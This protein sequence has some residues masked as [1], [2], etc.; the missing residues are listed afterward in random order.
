MSKRDR[1][2]N[3]GDGSDEGAQLLTSLSPKKASK[4]KK[5][6]SRSACSSV[7]PSKCRVDL[8]REHKSAKGAN[9]PNSGVLLFFFFLLGVR[10]QRSRRARVARRRC[11]EALVLED[12]L[13]LAL[14]LFRIFGASRGG[15]QKAQ[16]SE[17]NRPLV[18]RS[19]AGSAFSASAF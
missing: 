3:S 6:V 11:L 5:M 15:T 7:L 10:W 18:A 1:D 8:W 2:S 14:A 9:K 17:T 4:T 16:K 13:S 19:S 12:D